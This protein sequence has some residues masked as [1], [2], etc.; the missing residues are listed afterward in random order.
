MLVGTNKQVGYPI[1]GE[2]LSVTAGVVSRI[3]LQEYAQGGETLLAIQIDAA[4]NSG[5]SGGPVIN[6]N[7]Q[8]VGVA[9]QSLA[10]L[11][12][13]NIGAFLSSLSIYMCVN[14]PRHTHVV[15]HTPQPPKPT[16]GYV[17]PVDIL[18]HFLKDIE[19]HGGYTGFCSLGVKFQPMESPSLRRYKAL[20]EGRSGILV[21]KVDPLAPANEVLQRG[22]VLMAVDGIDLANDGTIPFRKGERVEVRCVE[23]RVYLCMYVRKYMYWA[24]TL[25]RLCQLGPSPNEPHTTS[26]QPQ[27]HYYFSQLYK[28]DSVQLTLL[29]EGAVMEV[30]VPVYIHK[31]AVAPHLN[32]GMPSYLMVRGLTWLGTWIHSSR[33]IRVLYLVRHSAQRSS[34][35][36]YHAMP[37]LPSSESIQSTTL[38]HPTKNPASFIHPSGGRHGLHC[39]DAPLPTLQ[40]R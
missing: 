25:C 27:L 24:L 16:P 19:R 35:H 37:R 12:S 28:G 14:P 18:R 40:P 9:F 13:E 11:D 23:G 20:P 26:P 32:N 22:D 1:G 21:T 4:I 10:T 31:L 38:A 8:L 33:P 29:R 2:S 5:N 15:T 17:I 6:E 3:E 30:S 36:H 34:L 39:A 7:D